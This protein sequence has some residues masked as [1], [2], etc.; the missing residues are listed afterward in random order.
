[1][2]PVGEHAEQPSSRVLLRTWQCPCVGMLRSVSLHPA[3]Q[4]CPSCPFPIPPHA[5][6]MMTIFLSL[7]AMQFL[8]D[9]PPSNYINSLQ[10]QVGG[11]CS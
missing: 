11:Q 7:T 2:G 4:R 9:F 1:M 6:F 3:Q 10:Q 5:A 8:F